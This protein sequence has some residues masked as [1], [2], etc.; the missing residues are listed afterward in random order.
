MESIIDF[1]HSTV[2]SSATPAFYSLDG[3]FYP[4][5]QVGISGIVDGT[6]NTVMTSEM[7]NSPDTSSGPDTRGRMWNNARS[8]GVLF[9]TKNAQTH[10]IDAS[11]AYFMQRRMEKISDDELGGPVSFLAREAV[12]GRLVC[13][14]G[15]RRLEPRAVFGLAMIGDGL[16]RAR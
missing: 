8:G 11:V 13:Q 6:S 15:Q 7:V 4:G 2:G 14:H 16:E 1:G 10:R 5:G 9:T 12:Q 3:I